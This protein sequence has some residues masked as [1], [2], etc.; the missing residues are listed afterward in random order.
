MLKG[1]SSSLI[2]CR[3]SWQIVTG[4]LR[5]HCEGEVRE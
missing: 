5:T 4:I 2:K 1:Y 3:P